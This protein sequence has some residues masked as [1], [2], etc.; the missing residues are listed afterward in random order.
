MEDID[1]VGGDLTRRDIRVLLLYEWRL[2]HRATEAV[3]NIC[4]AMGVGL[5]SNRVAQMWFNKF[6]SGQFDLIDEPRSGRP[7]KLD[8]DELLSLVEQEPRLT[9]MCFAELLGCSHTT[10]K[11]HL[12]QLGKSWRYGV[13]VPHDL[14]AAQQKSRAEICSQNLESHRN[15]DWLTNL[16][17]GDEKW[18]C[19]K[20]HSR[21][22]QWLGKG[23]VGIP[24]TIELRPK[25]IMICVWWGVRG[26]VHWEILPNNQ[27]INGQTYCK[28]LERVAEKLKGIQDRVYFLHDNAKPHIAKV[29]KEK[30]MNLGWQ[31]VPHPAYSPDIAPSDYHLFHS[32]EHFLDDT[33]FIDEDEIKRS[34]SEYFDS[35]SPEFFKNGILSLPERWRQVVHNNGS[36]IV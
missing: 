36:Y 32:M 15:F 3:R 4:G 7:E 14:S 25:K 33:K 21:K 11:N 31:M 5:V 26:I 35:L 28:Q 16:L 34:I 30:L 22:R 18:V 2:G 9:L 13:L 24:D 23:E 10:V 27:T 6:K 17:T 12:T 1:D 19:Y 8:N 20:N 29:T